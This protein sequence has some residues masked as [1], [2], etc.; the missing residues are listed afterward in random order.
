MFMELGN[1]RAGELTAPPAAP[2]NVLT[3]AEKKQAEAWIARLDS[4]D[5]DARQSAQQSLVALGPKVQPLLRQHA[6]PANKPAPAPEGLARLQECIREIDAAEDTRAVNDLLKNFEAIV[7]EAPAHFLAPDPDVRQKLARKI[8]F[9]ISDM[10]LKEA[11]E[12][13]APLAGI[14]MVLDPELEE[15]ALASLTLRV[16]EMN[17]GLALDWLSKLNDVELCAR[18]RVLIFSKR[19]RRIAMQGRTLELPTA[20]GENPW[21]LEETRALLAW[22]ESRPKNADDESR[23]ERPNLPGKL[24]AGKI[25]LHG[26]SEALDAWSVLLNAFDGGPVP[27][28]HIPDWALE[29]EK[30]MDA[31]VNVTAKETPLGEILSS[32]TKQAGINA[33]IDPFCMGAGDDVR[34]TMTSHGRSLREVLLD[35]MRESN[36]AVQYRHSAVLITRPTQ[37]LNVGQ[38]ILDLTPALKA[39]APR[40]EL[41]SR[42]A[43]LTAEAGVDARPAVVRGR[44]LA[45]VDP[46]TAQRAASVIEGAAKTGKVPAA[47]PAPWFFATFG[48]EKQK[49]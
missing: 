5:F 10:Q 4:D 17:A 36:L 30:K 18:G 32:I 31:K 37:R 14:P 9:E 28:A 38:R 47:P 42:L 19:A 26:L 40:D 21:T 35:L 49:K 41:L 33:I 45:W 8:S 48:K 13:L 7:R 3:A 15:V 1:I 34:I 6:N 43:S 44:W 27:A 24:E 25:Q 16:S 2:T 22:A 11:L 46:W 39:G 23:L 20:A 12:F 29:L